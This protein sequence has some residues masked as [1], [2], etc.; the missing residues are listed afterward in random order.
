MTDQSRSYERRVRRCLTESGF[1]VLDKGELKKHLPWNRS[2]D[3]CATSREVRLGPEFFVATLGLRNETAFHKN[4]FFVECTTSQNV[5]ELEDKIGQC[6]AYSDLGVPCYL[7]L[8]YEVLTRQL[9]RGKSVS[10][11][12]SGPLTKSGIGLLATRQNDLQ[13]ILPARAAITD[14]NKERFTLEHYPVYRFRADSV[15]IKAFEDSAGRKGV[16][17]LFI[18]SSIWLPDLPELEEK[19]RLA[20]I[21][22]LRRRGDWFRINDVLSDLRKIRTRIME[23]EGE[24]TYESW[25]ISEGPSQDSAVIGFDMA[26]FL[27]T[28][29]EGLRRFAPKHTR[30]PSAIVLATDSFPPFSP[31]YYQCHFAF[32]IF[33]R[34]EAREH[35]VLYLAGDV[36]F[37]SAQI[38]ASSFEIISQRINLE[39]LGRFKRWATAIAFWHYVDELDMIDFSV[40]PKFQIEGISSNGNGFVVDCKNS[41]NGGHF[42]CELIG[43]AMYI[44]PFLRQ[45]QTLPLTEEE[46]PKL[47]R[48]K[49]SPGNPVYCYDGPTI[50]SQLPELR[51]P[52]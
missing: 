33:F 20:L 26:S 13:C 2:P 51:E 15:I 9:D 3:F 11:R 19:R 21:L 49:Y 7:C 18:P 27:F 37:G 34:R 38:R 42:P 36:Q 28:I 1:S 17:P 30:W 4:Y 14:E 35:S 52:P 24:D 44:A 50:W 45:G 8:P 47:V 32:A 6:V 41:D 10:E 40:L 43:R 39:G 5:M 31:K 48:S 46:L 16:T 29:G 12:V 25:V 23:Q 22:E